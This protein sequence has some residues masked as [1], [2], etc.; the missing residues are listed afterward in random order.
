M[1]SHTGTHHHIVTP[2]IR[3][4][5]HKRLLSRQAPTA[6][7]SPQPTL[8]APPIF[9]TYPDILLTDILRGAIGRRDA[10]LFAQRL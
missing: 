4:D 8:R 1:I 10:I 6:R 2:R 3:R 5:A 9:T 7:R